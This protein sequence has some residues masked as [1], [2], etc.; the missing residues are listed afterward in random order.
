MGE[1]W[2]ALLHGDH[3]F[4]RTV[5]LKVLHAA[6]DERQRHAMIREARLG[7]LLA[8]PNVV[9]I[10]D[11]GEADGRVYIAMDLVRG[12]TAARLLDDARRRGRGAPRR[13]GPR[14]RR[15]GRAGAP[16][17]PPGGQWASRPGAPRREAREP[18]GRHIRHGPPAGSRGGTAGGDPRGRRRD[19]RVHAP[20]AD[21]WRRGRTGGRVR[22]RRDAHGA[23]HR[24][25]APAEARAE[26]RRH[27]AAALGAGLVG[28]G[29]GAGAGPRPDRG[30]VPGDRSRPP[31]PNGAGPGRGAG[32]ARG[33]ARSARTPG[34]R[35][36]GPHPGHRSGAARP[37]TAHDPRADHRARG[38]EGRSPRS[39]PQRHAAA[40]PPRARRRREDPG[41]A[42]GR[43]RPVA[44]ALRGG[45][46]LRRLA[47]H[48]RARDRGRGGAA[49]GRPARQHRSRGRRGPR[50]RGAGP[51]AADP[52]QPRAGGRRRGP[53]DRR[54]AA[55]RAADHDPRHVPGGAVPAGRGPRRA[56][57][58]RACRRGRPVPRS[59]ARRAR[60]RRAG[61]RA[62]RGPR[63]PAARDR[64]RSRAVPP[65]RTP[66]CPRRAGLGWR[67]RA[68]TGD[69][70]AAGEAPQPRR[71][72]RRILG[73]AAT[74]G[75]A[76]ARPAHR[77]RRSLPPGR[78][79]G[80]P[81][82][83]PSWRKRSSWRAPAGGSRCWTRPRTSR[84]RA[85]RRTPAR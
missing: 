7:G 19:A 50:P 15:S 13:R 2:E 18:A 51:D 42:A 65:E 60:E 53:G 31:V 43:A 21:R 59:R 35:G 36:P 16:P 30:A 38:R 46:V 84:K 22:A 9:P 52:R 74:V 24:P 37:A 79:Q 70:R 72:A 68:P 61:E 5:A 73:A 54:V 67:Q 58:A 57:A 55:R 11:V 1:V 77:V 4:S 6:S 49:A 17:L 40:R 83:R 20:G 69:G 10:Y 12:V 45:V 76:R 48:R 26:P 66:A 82:A 71:R 75:A 28:A 33:P 41:G 64:A 25:A 29:G 34:R 14:D 39:D 78:R 44:R 47:G 3:G 63:R 80:G 32:A 27:G 81:G 62:R 56:R 8:H 85:T 23:G